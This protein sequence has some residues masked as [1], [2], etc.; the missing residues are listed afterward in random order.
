MMTPSPFLEEMVDTFNRPRVK[1]HLQMISEILGKNAPEHMVRDCLISVSGQILYYSFAWP[2]F[3]RLFPDYATKNRYK[4][5]AN[6]VFEFSMGGITA[7][8]RK[9]EI[10]ED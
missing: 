3:S 10:K 9:L 7:C 2:V 1:M 5:W 6:H 8:K 4:E